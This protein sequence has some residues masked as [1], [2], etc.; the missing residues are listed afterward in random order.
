MRIKVIIPNSSEEF[1]NEAV[2]H[3]KQVA[4]PGTAIDV[5][6][7]SKGPVSMESFADEGYASPHLLDEIKKAEAEGYDAV[8]IDCAL[9][10]IHI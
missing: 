5:V 4:T 8:T 7:L 1:R 2:N 10:L 6:C 3:R 9:S